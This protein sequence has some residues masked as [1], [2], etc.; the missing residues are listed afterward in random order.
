M[1]AR[2]L[3]DRQHAPADTTREALQQEQPQ[4]QQQRHRQHP[5]DGAH[6][7][8]RLRFAGELDAACG[9]AVG[10]FRIHPLGDEAPRLSGGGIAHAAA[11]ARLADHQAAHP[12]LL[13]E[14]LELAVGDLPHPVRH[15]EE[16]AQR[17]Q[18]QDRQHRVPQ[19]ELMQA[20]V[21][22]AHGVLLRGAASRA[23]ARAVNRAP[24]QASSTVAPASATS[25]SQPRASAMR[26]R[27]ASA[28][29]GSPCTR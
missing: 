28:A 13:H 25:T 19:V 15:G 3:A 6:Q 17:E 26:R 1:R 23:G 18:R 4:H 9:Q 7:K 22:L 20:V 24:A 8:A 2:D 5:A 29:S 10:Q 12:P 11:D 27:R 21:V 16:V 14:A